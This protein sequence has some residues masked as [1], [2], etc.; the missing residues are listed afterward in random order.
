MD[1]KLSIKQLIVDECDKEVP[2]E[3]IGDDELLFGDESRLQLDSLDA[4]QLSMAL[5]RKFGIRIA[6]SKELRRAFATVAMLDAYL[7]K[8]EHA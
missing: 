1:R 3:E 6:D 7:T 5:Q 2:A 8:V 4:L